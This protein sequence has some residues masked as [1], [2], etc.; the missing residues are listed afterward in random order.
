MQR[1]VGLM[2]AMFAVF[3]SAHWEQEDMGCYDGPCDE[4][5]HDEETLFQMSAVLVKQGEAPPPVVGG[6][7]EM[8]ALAELNEDV[9]NTD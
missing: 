8:E 1:F 9:K 7:N 5:D 4:N 3:S 6:F 2:L